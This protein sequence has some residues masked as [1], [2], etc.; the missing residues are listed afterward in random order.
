V[1]VPDEHDVV[2][3][4][5]GIV[6]SIIAKEAAD[7]GM[8]VLVL[9]AGTGLART[10][11]GYQEQLE[12]FY[13]AFFKTPEGPYTFNPDAPQPDIPGIATPGADYF[14]ETGPQKYGSTYA[15]AAGGT[16]LHWLGTCLR[17]LPEDFELRTRFGRGLDWPIGYDDLAPDYARAEWEI[18]VSA[19]VE[20]QEYLGISFPEGYSYPMRR[21]P[22]S[23]LDQQLAAAVDGMTV[24]LGGE[25]RRLQVRSTPAGRNSTPNE[26]YTPVGAVDLGPDWGPREEGQ[27]LAR[28]IGE[29]CQGNSSCVPI[30]PVQAKYNAL[31]TLSKATATGRV[32]V[33][34]RAVASRV[35]VED[36]RVTGIEYL[37]YEHP[38]SPR[39]TVEVARGRT[40]VLACHVVENAKLML[41]SG[42]P[43]H[44]GLLGANLFDHPVLLAWGL[45]PEQAGAY[46]GPLSTSGIED[47]RGGAFRR[48][49][50]AFR[51][52]LGNDG[53]TWPMGA[54][55][56]SA[57]DAV[58]QDN[59]F[60]RPL[61]EALRDSLGRHVRIGCLVEQLP[62]SGNRVSIDSEHVDALG[63]P[64]PI[65]HYGFDE[66]VLDGM[67]AAA[68]V[69]R[70]LFERVGIQDRTDPAKSFVPNVTWKGATYAWGG[71]G[72][73]AGTHIMGT[74][75]SNSVVDDRQ[76]SWDYDNL[77]VPGP[78][79]MPTM[80]TANPTLTVAALAFRTARD[81]IANPNGR[82]AG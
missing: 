24:E 82:R 56:T 11:E 32:R 1:S 45:M 29:R 34:T 54:P 42:L 81:V 18:G 78:G 70:L 15:R 8:T 48:T 40:Y 73:F 35:L 72:H 65:I 75:P 80:G 68:D 59:L 51:I 5:A 22:P 27:K 33:V 64:R 49:H 30:C 7:A 4:G 31:K 55:D 19:D 44:D 41:M 79:S 53:W 17:M 77:V 57:S 58:N 37:R 63:L 47:L 10:F 9:E 13:G 69:A 14:V 6:G 74:D 67:A 23:W 43:T 16:T 38:D 28:D 71:A 52:E 61:R 36:R 46:R 50:G 20:D 3:V 25:Q 62:E 12:T 60:G 39:H 2:I 66:Y 21:I 76:R 26:G